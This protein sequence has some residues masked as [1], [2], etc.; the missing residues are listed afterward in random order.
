MSCSGSTETAENNKYT[1]DR[2]AA[3]LFWEVACEIQTAICVL[4]W[5]DVCIFKLSTT[6]ANSSLYTTTLGRPLAHGTHLKIS[7]CR[8]HCA[9]GTSLEMNLPPN[10]HARQPGRPAGRRSR[11]RSAECISGKVHRSTTRKINDSNRNTARIQYP[12]YLST[13]N[14]SSLN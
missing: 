4:N 1:C 3:L 2:L 14:N 9:F 7:M 6:L 13:A 5:K 12:R 10:C 11:Q 8:L